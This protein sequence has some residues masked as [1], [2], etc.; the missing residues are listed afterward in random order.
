MRLLAC[1]Q[2]APKSH[3]CSESA[4]EMARIGQACVRDFPSEQIVAVVVVHVCMH[5]KVHN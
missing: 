4:I 3:F 1:A 2:R 5:V